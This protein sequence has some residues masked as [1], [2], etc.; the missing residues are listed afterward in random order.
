MLFS[1]DV[2]G[3]DLV[4]YYVTQAYDALWMEHGLLDLFHSGVKNNALNLLYEANKKANIQVKTPVGVTEKKEINDVIMQG[5][6]I[7]S[8]VCTSSVDRVSRDCKLKK[9]EYKDVV[10]IPKLGFVDDILD[11]NKCGEATKNMNEYTT[12]EMD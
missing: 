6:S 7:S 2:R 11:I 12:E 9:Y 1:K 10:E 3:I 4:F 8:I 5:E